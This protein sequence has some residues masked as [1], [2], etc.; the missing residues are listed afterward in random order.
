[1]RL[2]VVH[3]QGEQKLRGRGR[4]RRQRPAPPCACAL[5][6]RR[7]STPLLGGSE[8][9]PAPPT[10]ISEGATS[11]GRLCLLLGELAV[12]LRLQSCI[13]L[14]FGGGHVH[15]LDGRLSPLGRLLCC[16][17]ARGGPCGALLGL[18][19]LGRRLQV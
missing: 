11:G 8:S 2:P 16:Q 14:D 6:P 7:S 17:L 9:C 3:K 10:P 5:P 19:E 12:L 4:P 13:R 15:L 18:E 1:M